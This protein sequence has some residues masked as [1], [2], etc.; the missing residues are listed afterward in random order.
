MRR[1][2]VPKISPLSPIRPTRPNV[3]TGSPLDRV[4]ERRDDP[5]F[6]AE[7]LAAPQALVAPIW[8]A[9]SFFHGEAAR[10]F[11][12]DETEGWGVEDRHW[13]FLGLWGDRPVFALDL[14]HHEDTRASPAG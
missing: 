4:A 5:A 7:A 8:R 2:L 13:I 9:Q 6:I 11:S 12:P 14:N 10:F 3:Y 1:T